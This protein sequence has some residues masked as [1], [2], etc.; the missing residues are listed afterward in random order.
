MIAEETVVG[1]DPFIVQSV[2]VANA[3]S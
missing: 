3:A 2:I 1:S